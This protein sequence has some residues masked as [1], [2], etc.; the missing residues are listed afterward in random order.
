MMSDTEKGSRAARWRGTRAWRSG[1]DELDA[2]IF[3]L[4]SVPTTPKAAPTTL[5]AYRATCSLQDVRH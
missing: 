3:D 2:M 4:P 5:S 1:R